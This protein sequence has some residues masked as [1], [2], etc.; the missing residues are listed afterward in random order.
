MRQAHAE[1]ART[2]ARRVVRNLLGEDR[3]TAELL[4]GDATPVLGHERTARC[5]DLALGASLTRR[6][7]ELAAIAALLVG[8]RE[9]GETWWSQTRGGKLPA[10]DEVLR[11]AVAIEPWTDLT[12]LEM[13][14]AWIAD[15]AADQLWGRPVAQVDLNSWQAEDRFDLPGGVKPGQRLVVHFD[16]GGRLD[17]VVTRRP[18]DDLGSN[19][20]FHSLRYSR[21][22]E[23]QW[24]WGV[25]AGL[26][27]HH[28]PGDSPDPYARK[29]DQRAVGILRAWALRHGA[30]QDLLGPTW[31]TVGDVVAAIERVDWMW[32]SAEWFGWWRGASALVDDSG[33]LPYRLDELAAG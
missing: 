33:Y 6:S 23:A 32:R 26:G 10:P 13:L 24:S 20:D 19:L 8:T 9:L 31:E 12:A 4:I 15:D 14:G 27:P 7:A 21:P 22:A 17:A 3:P 25:A 11:T 2:E 28:L 29:V 30:G 5:L 18:D 1:D 16:A